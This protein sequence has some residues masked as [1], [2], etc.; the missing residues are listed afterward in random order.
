MPQRT[1][2]AGAGENR[3]PQLAWTGVPACTCELVLLIEDPDAPLKRP[4][5]HL[6]LAAIP[7]SITS[8]AENALNAGSRPFGAGTA[9]FNRTG[10]AGPRPIRGHGPHSYVFQ[11]YALSEPLELGPKARPGRIVAAMAGKVIG[12]GRL[13]GIYER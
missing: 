9:S 10:Y 11:L 12:R 5:V 6:A 1:A 2:G 3:S 4:I 7:A 8:F 13:D